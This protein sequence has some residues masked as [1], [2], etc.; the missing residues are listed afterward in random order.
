MKLP[1]D[2][3]YRQVMGAIARRIESGELAPGSR[4]PSVREL[5]KEAGVTHVTAWQALR[6]LAAD[7]ILTLQ[8]G[9]G[10]YVAADAKERLAR[11]AAGEGPRKASASR[12]SFIPE[13]LSLTEIK[14]RR[15]RARK[16]AG[17]ARLLFEGFSRSRDRLMH[18]QIS[19]CITRAV[20][21]GRLRRGDRLPS[22]ADVGRELGVSINTVLRGYRDLQRSGLVTATFPW[23]FFV[24]ADKVHTKLRVFLMFDEFNAFKEDLYN[25]FRGELGDR[26]Q[27]DLFFHHY[28]R[29][30]FG[31]LLEQARG[32]YHTY[33][34]IPHPDRKTHAVLERFNPREILLI[35]QRHGA[36]PKYSIICQSFEGDTYRGLKSAAEAIRA[37]EEF[38][39]VD[40]DPNGIH[41]LGPFAQAIKR[42]FIRFCREEKLRSRV[43]R[44][45]SREMLRPGVA[46]LVIGEEDLVAL[47]RE[48][49]AASLRVGTDVGIV[50]YNESLL[51][52]IIGG[53][54][55]TLSTDFARMGRAAARHIVEHS[56]H[57]AEVNP[58]ALTI[59]ASLRRG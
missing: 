15:A 47:V 42:G 23:G 55:S 4:V 21:D 28:R 24:S 44:G 41:H 25:A 8:P 2:R 33:V 46:C 32:R 59:R 45:L 13:T 37:Y 34:I 40:P 35:D 19:G 48:V 58:S 11:A 9:S 10:S 20:A 3:L 30:V 38:V 36:D 7:G 29:D 52:Q 6:A 53:G 50:S 12:P 1:I 14:R 27:I 56:S 43:E 39:L 18:A 57:T 22:L 26:A 51:K 54:I 17:N 49:E 16:T 31:S 5:T